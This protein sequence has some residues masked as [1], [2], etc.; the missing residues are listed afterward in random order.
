MGRPDMFVGHGLFRATDDPLNNTRMLPPGYPYDDNS[1]LLDDLYDDEDYD[2]DDD[3]DELDAFD[4]DLA[5]TIA[6]ERDP[7]VGSNPLDVIS[8]DRRS[9]TSSNNVGILNVPV[10][11]ES[12]LIRLRPRSSESDAGTVYGWSSSPMWPEPHRA[13]DADLYRYSDIIEDDDELLDD[14]D[15]MLHAYDDVEMISTLDESYIRTIIRDTLSHYHVKKGK[16]LVDI[17]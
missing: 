7:Y 1:S 6:N 14:P 13:S 10:F 11:A 12:S 9:F 16:V 5:V 2:D 3:D 17:E 4:A 15:D 8:V